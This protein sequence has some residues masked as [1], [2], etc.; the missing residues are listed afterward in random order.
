MPG[1]TQTP[2]QNPTT[3][4]VRKPSWLKVRLPGG[5]EYARLKKI[6]STLKLATVCEEARCPNIGECWAGGT[7]TFML[8]G[9]VCTRGCRFCAV[10]TGNPNGWLDAE[11][12]QKLAETVRDS[13][14]EYVVLTSVDRDD[15]PD[16]GAAH[17]ARCVS[18]VREASPGILVEVLIPDFQ[19]EAAPLK[20]LLTSRPD[21]VAQNIETVARLTHRV[22]D[23]RAGYEQTLTLL[24]RVKIQEPGIYTKSSL[25]LG[26]GETDEEIHQCLADLRAVGVD[27]LTLGQ[28]LQPTVKHLPVE[29]FV[30]PETFAAWKTV[31]ERDYGFLY[32]AS[33]PLVRSSYRAGEY[34]MT[35]LINHNRKDVPA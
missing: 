9:E 11:E 26:L 18:A 19:G 24:E 27:I 2:S 7:A 12:P 29:R 15:L 31:A 14:W 34:F 25:M 16:G 23:R 33:G 6:S 3:P 32:C 20:T 17:F 1:L 8:M 28:Y 30:T 4:L 13:H 22:R 10:S 35:Q 5:E 21:V